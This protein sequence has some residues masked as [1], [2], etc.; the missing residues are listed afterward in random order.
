MANKI[1]TQKTAIIPSAP[2]GK[3]VPTVDEDG[4]YLI[5]FMMIVRGLKTM[6]RQV[7]EEKIKLLYGVLGWYNKAVV[8]ADLNLKLNLLWVSLRSDEGSTMQIS[9]A[10]NIMIPE[11]VLVGNYSFFGSST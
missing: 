2:L 7:R 10:L 3:R 9:S 5:D 6:P 4:K 11:A 8:Y 1:V